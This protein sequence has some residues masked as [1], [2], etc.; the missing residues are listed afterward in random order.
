MRMDQN[1]PTSAQD[2]VNV[3]EAPELS[4][5]IREYGEENFA[6]RI[7]NAIVAARRNKLITTTEVLANIIKHAVPI[8]DYEKKRDCVRRTFQGLR[9]AV[10][11][12]LTAIKKG[13]Q[14][15]L[16]ILP[17]GG[18]L[19]VISFHSLEDRL[20]KHFFLDQANPCICPPLFPKCTC[21]KLPSLK[22]VTKKAIIASAKEKTSNRRASS[23]KLRVAEKL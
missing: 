10:N 7:A 4:R 3:F 6:D 1:A 9:I 22:I 16:D 5:I 18:R 19:A 8:K 2:I 13:L 14:D 21:G 17:P 11:D 23:A 15:A 12:E 20:V